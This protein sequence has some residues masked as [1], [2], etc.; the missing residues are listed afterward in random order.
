MQMCML[1]A[2]IANDGVMMQPRLLS[3]VVT[4]NNYVRFTQSSKAYKT[5]LSAAESEIVQEAML[6]TIKNGT[7]KSTAVKGY[8]V[9]GKTGTAEIS[10]D[11][12][13]N[14]HAW[15]TGFVQDDEHP[16]AIC[17]ILEQA[18]GGGSKAAPIA[19]K[20]FA[21]AIDLGY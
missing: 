13:V 5:I 19:G 4:K 2:A 18:G 3:K 6:G 10:S 17:V 11:K 16:L 9:G 8:T 20:L 15:F 14:T 21:K 1:T 7:G 12:S